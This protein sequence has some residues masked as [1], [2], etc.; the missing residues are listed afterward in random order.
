[1]KANDDMKEKIIAYLKK[2]DENHPATIGNLT[3]AVFGEKFSLNKNKELYYKT[4][5][6]NILSQLETESVVKNLNRPITTD[7]AY[8]MKASRWVLIKY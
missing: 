3:F 7:I 6:F 8:I 1:M 5:V 2:C 4:Q